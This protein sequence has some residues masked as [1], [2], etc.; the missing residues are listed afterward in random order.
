MRTIVDWFNPKDEAHRKAFTFFC[1]NEIWPNFVI[2]SDVTIPMGSIWIVQ[3]LDKI[4][5]TK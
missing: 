4:T 2:P 3:I 1:E 5:E